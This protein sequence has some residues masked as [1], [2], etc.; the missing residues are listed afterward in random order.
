VPSVLRP[1]EEQI[2]WQETHRC[3]ICS[4]LP[5][6]VR[7]EMVQEHRVLK[8]QYRHLA[9][10]SVPAEPWQTEHLGGEYRTEVECENGHTFSCRYHRFR[11]DA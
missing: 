3:V 11:E 9:R 10:F 7:S 6:T 4:G 2:A 8:P 1:T 5:V